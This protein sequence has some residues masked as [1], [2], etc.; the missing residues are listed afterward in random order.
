MNK[1]LRQE[2]QPF[3]Y[4]LR[5]TIELSI[6]RILMQLYALHL[7]LYSRNDSFYQT[8]ARLTNLQIIL[9]QLYEFNKFARQEWN[10]M[11]VFYWCE[12][13]T[14]ICCTMLWFIARF[15]QTQNLTEPG[16]MWD[17]SLL[18]IYVWYALSNENFIILQENFL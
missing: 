8:C 9:M 18:V 11:T 15:H 12:F 17:S 16:K 3:I 10:L 7:I 13:L 4:I 14:S 5:L 6:R 1:F 2:L